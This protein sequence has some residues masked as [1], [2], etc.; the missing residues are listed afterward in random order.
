MREHT[1]HSSVVK[2]PNLSM[3]KKSVYAFC[4]CFLFYISVSFRIGAKIVVFQIL[5]SELDV[6]FGMFVSSESRYGY[7]FV[8]FISL[9]S[10]PKDLSTYGTLQC[11]SKI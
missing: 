7:I 2:S 10:S 3:K 4:M 1:T 11:H 8:S 5:I 6:F 9:V